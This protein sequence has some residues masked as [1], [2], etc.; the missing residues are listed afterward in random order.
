MKI[1]I[2]EDDP[3][4]ADMVGETIGKWGFETVKVEEFDQVLQLFL[5]EKPHLV[6]MD[7]NLPYFDGF[8]W[9]NKIREISKVPMVFLS[10]RTTPMDMIMA[11]NMGGDD[12]IQKPFH[13]DV[14]M[15]KMN[16]LLRRTYSYI[17]IS[18]NVMEHDGIVLNL[19][20]GEMFCGDMKAEL[21]K[22]EF[23]ILSILMKHKGTI[24]SREKMMRSL[25]ADE[26][27]VDDNTLTVNITRLRKKLAE[28][29]KEN[30]ITTKKGLGYIVQ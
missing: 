19:K 8:Y 27:F 13:T 30:F 14:L 4:I 10:S 16:A 6:L 7:I 11:M 28:L 3:T 2:V 5:R 24:I 18:T 17:E 23:K 25:W 22:N 9:C 29:G 26:S 15:A 20:D 1:M 12:F 21:T